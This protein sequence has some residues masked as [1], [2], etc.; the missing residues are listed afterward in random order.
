MSPPAKYDELWY[1]GVPADGL[2]VVRA[3]DRYGCIALDG[4]PVIPVIY[5][6]MKLSARH[7]LVQRDGLWGVMTLDHTPILPIAYTRIVPLGNEAFLCRLPDEGW[8]FLV[9]GREEEM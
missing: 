3:G 8:R 4:T 1:V 7:I 6:A 5:D 2:A 9:H